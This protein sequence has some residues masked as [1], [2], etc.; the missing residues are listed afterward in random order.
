TVLVVK[1]HALLLVSSTRGLTIAKLSRPKLSL[2]HHDSHSVSPHSVPIA[3]SSNKF[4]E[5]LKTKI[6]P[7]SFSWSNALLNQLHQ[8]SIHRPPKATKPNAGNPPIDLVKSTWIRI[9][10]VASA[11]RIVE[12]AT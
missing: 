1:R 9:V 4:R 8:D 3:T 2:V 12:D 11:L 5:K 6:K 7:S 10:L